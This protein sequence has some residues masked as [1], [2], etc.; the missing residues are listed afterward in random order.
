MSRI[1]D[2]G[3]QHSLSLSLSLSLPFFRFLF[4][5]QE[6]IKICRSQYPRV[7]GSEDEQIRGIENP[8]IV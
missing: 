4:L 2:I 6:D 8:R 7:Q 5:A 3:S 1:S